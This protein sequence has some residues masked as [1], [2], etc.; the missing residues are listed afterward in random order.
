MLFD[1]YVK[2]FALIDELRIE[3]D[4]GLN[5][6]TG[7]TGSG[8]SI[9]VDALSLVLGKKAS[10][11][12]VRTGE[13]KALI[14]ASFFIDD[15]LA[16][17]V[18]ERYGI[19]IEEDLLIIS[20][21]ISSD[22]RSISR[23]NGR[24]VT[25]GDIREVTSKIIAI[26]GQNEHEQFLTSSSQLRLVDGFGQEK[27]R[28]PSDD[29]RKLYTEYQALQKELLLLNE[30]M[31]SSRIKREL[32]LLSY[33]INEIKESDIKQ[34]EKEEIKE[35]LVRLENAEKI[36]NTI[37]GAYD[38]IYGGKESVL[39]KLSKSINRMESISE[40]LPDAE[41]WLEVLNDAYYSLEDL[42]HEMASNEIETD[43]NYE[44]INDL[45]L[46][47][48]RINQIFR[49]YGNDYSE[50]MAY[51]QRAE[52]KKERI[53]SRDQL[54]LEYSNRMAI[55]ESD[56]LDAAKKISAERKRVAKSL[57]HEL[58]KELDS[59]HMK[60]IQFE[61][62]FSEVPFSK[63]G[64]DS[65]DFMIS[66]NKGEEL[67]PISQTASGGEIS[68]FMLAFKTVIAQTDEIESLIFDEI[69]TGVSGIAAQRI[70][71]K[72]K[73]IS[74]YRQVI[75][76]THLPQIASYSNE[77][78]VVEKNQD[79]TNTRTSIKKLSRNERYLE[80]AKMMSGTDVTENAIQTAKD[81]IEKNS[82]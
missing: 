62:F 66:F 12:V 2:N 42:A 79:K 23:V 33:E 16:K 26:H 41:K 81:M 10:K 32:D 57:E 13:K 59:L 53:L 34:N 36:Q 80:L 28:K 78:F 52:E 73:E 37:Q 48:D 21:E 31:D 18:S 55:I 6:I 35:N 70:G 50:V 63:T 72:L 71:Q 54:N 19:D 15:S 7:E 1:L 3:F 11:T 45:N 49:K 17:E 68:R 65:L 30:D 82:E 22:G 43:G 56:L 27:L 29:Y 40:Y 4:K 9:M 67:K 8:K 74:R 64:V 76:I 39:D 75:C 60:N 51:L 77:H 61:I 25:Q 38:S 5:I 47:L 44:A 24:T 14:E 20:R 69:D 58:K 46:R